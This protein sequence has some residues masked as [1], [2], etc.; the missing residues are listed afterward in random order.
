MS[1]CPHPAARRQA[2]DRLCH[3]VDVQ[4]HVRPATRRGDRR[5][6]AEAIAELGEALRTMLAG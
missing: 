3:R 4:P 6:P 1:S 5:R 2:D